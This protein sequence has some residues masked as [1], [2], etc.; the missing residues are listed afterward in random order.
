MAHCCV[1]V[2]VC[3]FLPLS[4]HGSNANTFAV[5]EQQRAY[6]RLMQLKVHTFFF[7]FISPRDYTYIIFL[8]YYPSWALARA[9]HFLSLRLLF[10]EGQASIYTIPFFVRPQL[11]LYIY[12]QTFSIHIIYIFSAEFSPSTLQTTWKNSLAGNRERERGGESF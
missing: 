2:C 3:V 9:F 11:Q 7:L 5:V 10:N 6:A 4:L 12:I 1:Y 8:L